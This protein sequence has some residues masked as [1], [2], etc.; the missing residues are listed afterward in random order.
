MTLESLTNEANKW[1]VFVFVELFLES[2]KLNPEQIA[3]YLGLKPDRK[4]F[5]AEKRFIKSESCVSKKHTFVRSQ[6]GGSEHSDFTITNE[7]FK[8]VLER[9]LVRV[10]S[11]HEKINDFQPHIS[12]HLMC[13]IGSKST[14]NQWCSLPVDLIKRLASLGI[15]LMIIWKKFRDVSRVM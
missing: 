10:D 7:L 11:V 1:E 14:Q 15:S 4:S 13:A 3:Q 6:F 12:M 2:E 9:I 5:A 8:G